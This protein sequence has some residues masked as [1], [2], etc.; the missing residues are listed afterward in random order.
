MKKQNIKKATGALALTAMLALTP[1]VGAQQS[2]LSGSVSNLNWTLYGPGDLSGLSQDAATLKMSAPAQATV[3]GAKYD[4]SGKATVLAFRDSSPFDTVFAYYDQQLSD[5]GFTRTARS[6]G[7]NLG[8]AT[9]QRGGGQIR[10]RLNKEGSDVYRAFVDLGNVGDMAMGAQK[11]QA[12]TAAQSAP[13]AQ[14]VSTPTV[15]AQDQAGVAYMLYGADNNLSNLTNDPGMV[16][17]SVPQGATIT[18]TDVNA[19]GDL[20]AQVTSGLTLQQM[21]D[22]Y[23]KQFKAQGFTLVNPTDT[24]AGLD[25][26]LTNIYERNNKSRVSFSVEKEDNYRLVWDFQNAVGG[27]LGNNVA[28]ATPN[29]AGYT[30]LYGYD[31]GGLG[32]DFYGPGNLADLT[33]DANRVRFVAPVGAT[34][35]DVNKQG[36]DVFLTVNTTSTLAQ[37]QTYYDGQFQQQGFERVGDMSM[38]GEKAQATYKRSANADQ[39][40]IWSAEQTAPNTYQV[41]FNF[42]NTGS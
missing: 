24:G 29:A 41:I 32:Y 27:T 4:Q 12:T 2:V 9:Y 3:L 42:Q 10:L 26:A 7:D 36:E 5:Q 28:A 22:F 19:N 17:F 6:V 1:L 25:N 31:S 11:G 23:D 20:S 34:V 38:Q 13:A 21:M 8:E 30:P 16:S 18:N 33:P 15:Q 14:S 35:T 40:I 39:R 37:L